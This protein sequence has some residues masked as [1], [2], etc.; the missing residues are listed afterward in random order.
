MRK[1]IKISLLTFF[2][3]TT[4]YAS[5]SQE[6]LKIKHSVKNTIDN[7]GKLQTKK[8]SVVDNFKRMFEDGKVSGQARV[9]YAG[10]NQKK[11]NTEDTY[12]TALAGILKYELAE[13]SGFNAGVAFY[14]SQDLAVATGKNSK[15]NTELS[16]SSG[17]Y[18]ELQEAYL[19]YKLK[20]INLRVGRQVLDTPLADSDDIRTVQNSFE[21]Y[22]VSYSIDSVELMAGHIMSWQGSDAGLATKWTDTGTDGVN[23]AGTVYSD[24]IEFNLWYYNITGLTNAVYT[25]VGASHEFNK[26]INLHATLQYLSESEL[27]NSGIEASIYGVFVELDLYDFRFSIAYNK[28]KQKIGKESFSGFGG[29]TLFTNMDTMILD[30]LTKDRETNT[31]VTGISYEIENFAFIYAYGSFEGDK[32]T[33]GTK[34]SIVEQNFVIE[35]TPSEEFLIAAIVTT[36]E[37]KENQVKTDNDFIRSQIVVNYNF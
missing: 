24:T 19:N 17:A 6:H 36:E 5:E 23:F 22:I 34:E 28:S 35:Y 11:S 3:T 2:V 31:F 26:E 4:I 20:D 37:D 30:N 33:S 13:Y 12:A 32:D 29:G 1:I 10:Y 27:D 18:T 21:A 25:D 15:R 16:T 8:V 14:T 7:V 9:E